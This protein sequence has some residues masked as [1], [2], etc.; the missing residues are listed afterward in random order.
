MKD[1]N[2]APLDTEVLLCLTLAETDTSV[3]FESMLCSGF[4]TKQFNNVTGFVPTFQFSLSDSL[5]FKCVG[6]FDLPENFHDRG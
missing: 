5:Q 2:L 6:W 3:P 1:P 4:F